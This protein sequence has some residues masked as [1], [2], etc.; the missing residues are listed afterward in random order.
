MLNDIRTL[1]FHDDIFRMIGGYDKFI[2][3]NM[4]F[5]VNVL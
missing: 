3:V 1:I 4:A 5:R 2:W